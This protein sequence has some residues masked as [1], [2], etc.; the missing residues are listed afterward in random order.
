MYEGRYAYCSVIVDK[1]ISS[2]ICI[3]K[4]VF[5]KVFISK[6][7]F[8]KCIYP[9]CIFAKCTR[10]ACLLSI[11]SLFIYSKPYRLS[12]PLVH[13]GKVG[14]ALHCASCRSGTAAAVTAVA[15]LPPR[16]SCQAF[17]SDAQREKGWRR[18]ARISCFLSC[19]FDPACFAFSCMILPTRARK[20]L[21]TKAPPF[22]WSLKSSS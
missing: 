6:C 16:C 10:L 13:W 17:N 20:T 12:C 11:A 2:T 9:K 21:H 7:I 5:P 14:R 19:W 3:S 1:K 8:P 15:P 18:R 4:S 22:T